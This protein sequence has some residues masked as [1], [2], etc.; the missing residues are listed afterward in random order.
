MKRVFFVAAVLLLNH[1]IVTA[2]GTADVVEEI[3]TNGVINWTAQY[4]EATGTSIVNR[5]KFKNPQQAILMAQRGAEVIAKANLLEAVSGVQVIRETTVKDLILESDEIKTRLEGTIKGSRTI[6]KAKVEGD[7]V[8]VTV[9]LP[10]YGNNSV[11]DVVIDA[12][13]VKNEPV[14]ASNSSPVNNNS[15]NQGTTEGGRRPTGTPTSPTTSA[16]TPKPA[17]VN[18][19]GVVFDFG[20]LKFDPTMFPV[21]MDEK[22]NIIFDYKKMYEEIKKKGGKMPKIVTVG[23]KILDKGVEIV[24]VLETGNGQIKI[25]T[26]KYPKLQNLLNKAKNTGKF[27][28]PILKLFM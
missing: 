26:K 9:R 15:T 24:K 7:A 27:I 16:D 22:G 23:Q 8:T 2:Q 10:L 21:I 6:G 4:V 5:D 28:L 14:P 17:E 3:G 18:E 1:F 25:D 12:P 19:Q 11:A 20:D 13:Q